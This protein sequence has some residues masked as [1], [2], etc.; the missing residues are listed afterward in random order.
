LAQPDDSPWQWLASKADRSI[1]DPQQLRQLMCTASNVR[2]VA[3]S[4]L[5]K[6]AGKT[7]AVPGI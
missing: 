2:F 1:D 3:G 4:F 5:A 7:I 6:S